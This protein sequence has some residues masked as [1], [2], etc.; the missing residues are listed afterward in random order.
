MDGSIFC[1]VLQAQLTTVM[2]HWRQLV[3]QYCRWKASKTQ[4]AWSTEDTTTKLEMKWRGYRGW[5]RKHS[6]NWS[7]KCK[8]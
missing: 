8:R 2:R 1:I 5:L 3:L 7:W 6:S 4:S